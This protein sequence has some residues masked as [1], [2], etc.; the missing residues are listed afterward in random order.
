MCLGRMTYPM[1][2]V[3]EEP[4]CSLLLGNIYLWNCDKFKRFSL[5]LT[6]EFFCHTVGLF[7]SNPQR[8]ST[9]SKRDDLDSFTV[10]QKTVER[11]EMFPHQCSVWP[12]WWEIGDTCTFKRMD[13]QHSMWKLASFFCFNKI[14]LSHANL[15]L[16]IIS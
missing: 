5:T 8:Y 6:V 14:T 1:W 16:L 11:N 3:I 4:F 9:I 10:W 15:L 2:T 13:G 7:L 12:L